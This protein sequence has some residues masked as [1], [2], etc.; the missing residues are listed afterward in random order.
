MLIHGLGLS[1]LLTDGERKLKPPSPLGSS[2]TRLGVNPCLSDSVDPFPAPCTAP[3]LTS[4]RLVGLITGRK[5]RCLQEPK[6]YGR[7]T[8]ASRKRER[9]LCVAELGRASPPE[10]HLKRTCFSKASRARPNMAVS[11]MMPVGP[12]FV[13]SGCT[14]CQ[15]GQEESRCTQNKPERLSVSPSAVAHGSGPSHTAA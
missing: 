7:K 10:R 12:W 9:A 1:W 3:R 8:T 14:C 13:T 5:I 2:V 6:R 4:H 11:L 15:T